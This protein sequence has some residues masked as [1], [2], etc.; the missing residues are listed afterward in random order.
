MHGKYELYSNLSSSDKEDLQ[1][2]RGKRLSRLEPHIQEHTT[3]SRLQSLDL[4]VGEM[5]SSLIDL[6]DKVSTLTFMLDTFMKEMKGMVVEDVVVE[7]EVD[8]GN[9]A[10]PKEEEVMEEVKEKKT[11]EDDEKKAAEGHVDKEVDILVDVDTTAIQ[12]V[13]PIIEDKITFLGK[14]E[15]S[16]KRKSRSKK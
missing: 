16:K 1:K 13:P 9:A 2:I 11:E 15:P 14:P 12:T 6:H 7:E 8:D 5:K 3:L 4:E 10:E